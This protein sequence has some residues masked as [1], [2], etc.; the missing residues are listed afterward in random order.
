MTHLTEFALRRIREGDTVDLDDP[1]TRKIL[2][3]MEQFAAG[4]L[5][6]HAGP[7]WSEW[8]KFTP[9]EHIAWINGS[10]IVAAQ[11]ARRIALAQR[12]EQGF[13]LCAA[14]TEGT[15]GADRAA[16]LAALEVPRG[17]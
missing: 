17:E 15:L 11:K 16:A 3:A 9:L 10:R 13:Q 12:G 2:N 8:V 4:A 6:C 14:D 1:D 5:E 7:N